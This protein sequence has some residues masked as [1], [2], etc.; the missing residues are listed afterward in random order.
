M[1]LLGL[2]CADIKTL[3]THWLSGWACSA[4]VDKCSDK[5]TW[6]PL[7][8]VVVSHCRESFRHSVVKYCVLLSICQLVLCTVAVTACYMSNVW[9]GCL[10]ATLPQCT[11]QG[12]TI[13]LTLIF[14]STSGVRLAKNDLGVVLGSVWQKTAV[15]DSVLVLQ[16]S[17]CCL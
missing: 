11:A 2:S 16:S 10:S 6:Q 4:V 14:V 7:S 5:P 9:R 13:F 1:K 8:S 17:G 12:H 3:L 15:F